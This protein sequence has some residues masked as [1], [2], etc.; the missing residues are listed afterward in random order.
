[1]PALVRPRNSRRL[2]RSF[3]I[4]I[5]SIQDGGVRWRL[6]GCGN[7]MG[8]DGEIQPRDERQRSIAPG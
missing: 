7:D 3:F 2:R 8:P 1:M 4:A 5:S 6:G